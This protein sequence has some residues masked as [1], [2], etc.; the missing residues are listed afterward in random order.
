MLGTKQN[1]FDDFV[2]AAEYLIQT[3]YTAPSRLAVAGGSNGG[4]LMGAV[5]TQ[6][7]ELF[8]AVVIQV[9]LLDMLRYHRFL[10]AR[11]WIP[12]YGSA[13]NPEQ[14]PWL[15]AYSPYHRVRPGV[16]YPAVLLATAESDTRVD[17]MHARKMTA[18]LQAAT[19]SDHPVLLRLESRAGH[20][21]GKP[22]SKVLD[23]LVDTWTFIARELEVGWRD[24]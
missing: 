12:E 3:R 2:A 15:A 4:L 8:R 17:P 20:G 5:L 11:L 6:R 1:T 10:I 7:P 24:A 18:R 21:A 13:D 19:S 16:A 14:F 22:V 23:E 9:P